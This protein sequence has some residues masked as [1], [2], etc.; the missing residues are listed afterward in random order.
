M[1]NAA[2]RPL[3]RISH[4]IGIDL[5]ECGQDWDLT[6][7]DPMRI[8]E[9]CDIYEREPLSEFDKRELM[10]LIVA[11]Y[12]DAV[13]GGIASESVWRRV[14]RLLET[15]FTIHKEV[16]EYWSLLKETDAKNVFPITL[17]MREVWR[18]SDGGEI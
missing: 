15:D 12:D 3:D 6:C 5:Y 14:A 18:R 10:R 9:F 17:I 4:L 16:I 7:A 11:S 1:E 13:S 2:S 8:E